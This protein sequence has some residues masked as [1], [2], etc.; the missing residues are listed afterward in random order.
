MKLKSVVRIIWF[1]TAH[2]RNGC[3]YVIIFAKVCKYF[4]V[5]LVQN[6]YDF[7]YSQQTVLSWFRHMKYSSDKLKTHFGM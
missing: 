4:L 2:K 3:S 1:H 5:K 6:V 7:D